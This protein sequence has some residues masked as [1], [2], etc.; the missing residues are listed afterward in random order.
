MIRD[1]SLT[2]LATGW[3]TGVQFSAGRT[4][5][6][7]HHLVNAQPPTQQVP[8][9]FSP[10]AKAPER[11]DDHSPPCSEVMNAWSPTSF[12][13]CYHNMI[14][15]YLKETELKGLWF[16]FTF[17]IT[18]WERCRD[19]VETGV[20]QDLTGARS[21]KGSTP[22]RLE[23]V[24]G[25]WMYSSTHSLTSA[26]DRCEWTASRPDRFTSRERT[27]GTHWIGGWVGPRTGLDAVVKRKIPSP[28]REWN[29]TTPIVPA[30]SPALYRLSYHG[31]CDTTRHMP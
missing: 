25:E 31:S 15:W 5:T 27:P 26:P 14:S 12:V 17:Q 11:E 13:S 24:M 22:P 23:G 7:L 9:D 10:R 2:W 28:H 21:V 4:D 8:E 30:R 1:N 20:A 3:T 16:Q 19:R 29:P 6:Y 18:T